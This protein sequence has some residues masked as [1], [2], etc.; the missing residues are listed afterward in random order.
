[1]PYT[2]ITPLSNAGFGDEYFEVSRDDKRW[3]QVN[4]NTWKSTGK[5][6]FLNLFKPNAAG[7]DFE[8]EQHI[9]LSLKEWRTLMEYRFLIDP[10][11]SPPASPTNKQETPVSNNKRGTTSPPGAPMKKRAVLIPISENVAHMAINP[12]FQ[13]LCPPVAPVPE[14]RASASVQDS[15]FPTTP[16]SRQVSTVVKQVRF[17]NGGETE[18]D[19]GPRWLYNQTHSHEYPQAQNVEDWLISST[20]PQ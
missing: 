15:L 13:Y 20:Q 2:P 7:D 8:R 1:M 19:S 18:S 16:L 4:M 14:A 6:I 17:D 3:V 5:Y 10:E 9:T 12:A 11:E